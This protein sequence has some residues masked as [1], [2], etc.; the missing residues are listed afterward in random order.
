[1]GTREFSEYRFFFT[2]IP[3][4]F[5]IVC[6]WSFKKKLFPNCSLLICRDSNYFVKPSLLK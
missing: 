2:F 6:K 4:Y 1:M 3:K 5:Y